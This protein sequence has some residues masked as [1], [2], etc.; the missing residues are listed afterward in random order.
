MFQ[1][2]LRIQLSLTLKACLTNEETEMEHF[3]ILHCLL[4]CSFMQCEIIYQRRYREKWIIAVL[5][6]M[7]KGDL[8]NNPLKDSDIKLSC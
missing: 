7:C 2:N 6:S 1:L 5:E 3:Y 8:T 4:L